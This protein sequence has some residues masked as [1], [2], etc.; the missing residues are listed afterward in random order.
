MRCR[1]YFAGVDVEAGALEVLAALLD[2]LAFFLV[3]FFLLLVAGAAGVAVAA[4]ADDVAGGVV[5]WAN[6]TAPK[7]V[8]TSAA[9]KCFI[10]SS[11]VET[12][13]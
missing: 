9:T 2:F 4:G 13:M 12:E 10:A 1:Y 5:P 11:F 7:A 3:V 8:I 6:A